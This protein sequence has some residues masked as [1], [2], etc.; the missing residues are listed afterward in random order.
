MKIKN[1]VLNAVTI[2]TALTFYNVNAQQKRGGDRTDPVTL[3]TSPNASSLGS[4]GQI[5]VDLFTGQPNITIGL[6]NLEVGNY[7][8]PISINYNLSTIKPE[9]HPGWTGLG[10][11]LNCGGAITRIVNGGVD[12]VMVSGVADPKIFSYYDN[13]SKLNGDDWKN[14]TKMQ[15]YYNCMRSS[16]PT[17]MCA[18]PAPDEFMFNV[19][20]MSGSFYKNHLGKWVVKSNKNID[21]IVQEELMYDFVLQE[22]GNHVS[23][24]RSFN[25]KRIIYGFTLTDEDGVKYTF[26]KNSTALEFSANSDIVLD[27]YNPNFVVKTWYLTKITLPSS[28]EILFEYSFDKKATMVQH[29]TSNLYAYNVVGGVSQDVKSGSQIVKSLERMYNV[30]LARVISDDTEIIFNKSFSNE[31]DYNLQ[32]SP[33][34]QYVQYYTNHYST[35]YQASNLK[36][37]YKLDNFIVKSRIG[38]KQVKKVNFKYLENVTSRL[39]LEEIAETGGSDQDIPKKHIFEYNTTPL[40]AYNSQRTDHW[41]YY[42]G[43]NFFTSVAPAEGTRYSKAQLKNNYSAY[44]NPSA[45][46]MKAGT[47]TKIT[48]P[49]KG[50]SEFIY[51]PHDFSQVVQRT[52]SNFSLVSASNSKEIAGGL[53]I[54]K[55][56]SNSENS[57]VPVVMEYFYVK[58]YGNSNSISSGILSG[59]SLYFEE[60]SQTGFTFYRLRDNSSVALSNTNGNHIT[61]SKVIE[62]R[63]DN[64][65]TEFAYSNHDNGF[66]DTVANYSFNSTAASFPDLIINN[67][68]YNSKECERGNILFE[69]KYSSVNSLVEESKYFYNDDQSR[70]TNGIRSIDYYEDVYGTS[71]SELFPPCTTISQVKTISKMSA[72]SIFTHQNYLKKKENILYT[73]SGNVIAIEEFSYANSEK[74][75][76]LRSKKTTNSNGD[77]TEE[78][79]NYAP[80]F[81]TAIM[82]SITASN[83]LDVV[84]RKVE[85]NSEVIFQ[86]KNEYAK[87]LSTSNLLLKKSELEKKGNEVILA[88]DQILSYDYYDAKGNLLQFKKENS[89]R[90]SIIWGYNLS[91]PIAKL[92]NIEYASIPI[93]TIQ[94][95]QTKS[96]TGTEAELLVS[97]NA[98][99]TMF[100]NAMITT[101]T[102]I[103]LVGISSITDFKGLKSIFHYDTFGR[104]MTVRDNDN[105]LLTENQYH[106][107]Q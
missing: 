91:K 94:A 27:S 98:L 13:F 60:G 46:F 90:V 99:R 75:H 37:W 63:G 50:F 44:R 48:Y 102:Y 106:Y 6:Y 83:I 35:A 14:S 56:I 42:N 65:Y 11:N 1:K 87:D 5:P 53:R 43:I 104:L 24:N 57:G 81:S 40:P 45:T 100:P 97:L 82:N 2:L 33:W 85:S 20:G 103:P 58:D 88:S 52:I 38:N 76:Q 66:L 9:Q 59:R 4:F 79:F 51:E 107:K 21:I 10:W 54:K 73:T 36:H 101:Y 41:G 105:N 69:K 64:S 74:L 86:H 34:G 72:Y 29:M 78:K 89:N 67:L 47:L 22:L 71:S 25:I 16:F 15:E 77:V 31:L 28:R 55:I 8:L 19:N 32:N 3:S 18:Y 49:T 17:G 92:E 39:F 93:G 68:S 80:D 61:Y 12:E 7:N 30:Y 62:K 26:G 70:F 84:V 23:D 96:N 95:I